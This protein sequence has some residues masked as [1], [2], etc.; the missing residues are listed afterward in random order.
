MQGSELACEDNAPDSTSDLAP[1]PPKQLYIVGVGASAGGLEASEQC[2]RRDAAGHGAWASSSF[3]IFPEF[4]K[5]D[6]RTRW[7]RHTTMTIHRA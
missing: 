3:S 6:G 1:A 4:Q 5:P 7:A 2:F